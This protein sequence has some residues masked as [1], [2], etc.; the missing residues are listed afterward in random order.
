MAMVN[1]DKQEI[2]KIIGTQVKLETDALVDE[3]TEESI[4]EL[5][6]KIREIIARNVLSIIKF[7]HNVACMQDDLIITVKDIF[8]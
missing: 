8:K 7:E 6:P 1:F 4:K 2:V 3:I 5:R